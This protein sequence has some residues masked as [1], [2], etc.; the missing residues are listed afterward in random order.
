MEKGTDK[1]VM[2]IDMEFI[3]A[4]PF[5]YSAAASYSTAEAASGTTHNFDIYSG[6]NVFAEPKIYIC[7]TGGTITDAAQLKNITLDQL[8]KFRAYGS[9]RWIDS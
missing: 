9:C 6:G 3:A 7:A 2:N 4:N 1:A 8:F 5:A